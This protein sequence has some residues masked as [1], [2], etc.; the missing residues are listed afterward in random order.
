MGVFSWLKRHPLE[1]LLL[2]GTAAFAAPMALGAI[3]PVA[4]GTGMGEGLA[5]GMLGTL[6]SM[7]PEQAAAL[8]AQNA[9]LGLGA[10]ALTLEAA[11]AA[12]GGSATLGAQLGNA[13]RMLGKAGQAGQAL[14]LLNMGGQPPPTMAAMPPPPAA[15]PTQSSADIMFGG[16]QRQPAYAPL[17]GL[18]D[19]EW[20][21]KRRLMGASYG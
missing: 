12:G 19:P 17:A 2:G 20:E 18:L 15:G 16:Q 4:A 9:G 14:G 10:D 11:N 3:A 6:G 7:G 1:A 21:K 8:A 5:A 13:G